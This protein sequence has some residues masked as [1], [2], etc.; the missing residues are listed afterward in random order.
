VFICGLLFDSCTFHLCDELLDIPA[1]LLHQPPALQISL[2][3]WRLGERFL[4]IVIQRLRHQS[5][6]IADDARVIEQRLDN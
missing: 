2:P 4:H 6:E 1:G 5:N 3:L